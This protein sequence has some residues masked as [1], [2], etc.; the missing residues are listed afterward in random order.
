MR[1]TSRAS[2]AATL[3]TTDGTETGKGSTVADCTQS[4]S[5]P[6]GKVQP[7]GLTPASAPELGAPWDGPAP[8]TLIDATYR[9][10]GPLG[11]GGMGVV[12]LARDER[13]ERDVAIKFVRP[14]LLL[15]RG[16][17]ERFLMEAR[18]AARLAVAD[19]GLARIWENDGLSSHP[20]AGTPAYMSPDFARDGLTAG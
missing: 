17:S 13:L 18:A 6:T 7:T 12:M 14:D 10:V 15:L 8:G 2:T 4:T 5:L 11:R 19:M 1:M 3:L 20:I 16:A 9:V